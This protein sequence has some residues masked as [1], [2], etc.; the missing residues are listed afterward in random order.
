L[1]AAPDSFTSKNSKAE[2]R[3]ESTGFSSGLER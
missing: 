3:R 2:R 1:I